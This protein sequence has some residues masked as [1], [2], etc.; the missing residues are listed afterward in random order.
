MVCFGCGLLPNAPH[1]KRGEISRFY[2]AGFLP[3]L[4]PRGLRRYSSWSV[5]F[6][7][8]RLCFSLCRQAW[9]AGWL[10]RGDCPRATVSQ[11]C[12]STVRS[13]WRYDRVIPQVFFWF[14]LRRLFF[15][16]FFT[17]CEGAWRNRTYREKKPPRILDVRKQLSYSITGAFRKIGK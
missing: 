4:V 10:S 9:L 13:V 15:F 16:F 14:L 3:P 8:E 5:I 1:S 12:R 17:S 11:L 7:G 2:E 6:F